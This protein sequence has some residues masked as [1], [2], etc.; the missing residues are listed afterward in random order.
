MTCHFSRAQQAVDPLADEFN[1]SNTLGKVYAEMWHEMIVLLRS[2]VVFRF[3][4]G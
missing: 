3:T 2:F 1:K 4:S